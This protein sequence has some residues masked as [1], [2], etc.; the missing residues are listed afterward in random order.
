[1]RELFGNPTVEQILDPVYATNAFYDALTNVDG[2]ETLEITVAAQEVQRSGFPDA[3]ADHEEDGRALSSALTGNSK[4]SFSCDIDDDAEAGDS[5]L[6]DNGLT[7]RADD[8]RRE[9]LGVASGT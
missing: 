5:A 7:G 9:A 1:M 4:H 3:Y 8:V 2:Y 6:T